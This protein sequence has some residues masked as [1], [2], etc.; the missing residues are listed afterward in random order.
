MRPAEGERHLGGQLRRTQS[1]GGYR[2]DRVSR[3]DR[4][5][6]PATHYKT[7]DDILEDKDLSFDEKMEALGTWEQDARQL[8]TASN[9]GMEGS[10]EGIEP[11]AHHRLGE[12]IRAK[13]KLGATPDHK[14]SQ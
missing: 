9:E 3:E 1:Y 7:P 14:P 12:V 13:K 5:K 2:M 11:T 8:V 6:H 4:M 10:E